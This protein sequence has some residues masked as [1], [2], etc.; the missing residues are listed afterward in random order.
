MAHQ[1]Y[2]EHLAMRQ[3]CPQDEDVRHDQYLHHDYATTTK[4]V[5]HLQID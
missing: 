2:K 5:Q 1:Q 4:S 3:S